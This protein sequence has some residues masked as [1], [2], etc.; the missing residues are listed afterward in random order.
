MAE[1]TNE[2]NAA[3]VRFDP[4]VFDDSVDQVVL[5][6]P[7][8]VH[9]FG[10]RGVVW[11]SLGKLDA[12]RCE[13]V[14]NA[15]EAGLPI[16]IEPVVRDEI[17]RAK[18]FACLRR[19]LLKVLVE[20]LFPTG[21]VDVGGVRYHTVEVK[22]DGVVPVAGDH[23]PA[24]GLPHRSLSCYQRTSLKG[25]ANALNHSWAQRAGATTTSK[26]SWRK[27]RHSHPRTDRIAGVEKLWPS[28]PGLELN[29]QVLPLIRL[30]R[31]FA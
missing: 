18:C 11:M 9:C 16:H 28:F 23:T 19:A 2:F 3:L 27:A 12:A 24:V 31:S 13:K 4:F 5:A 14:A 6:V 10:L 1:L 25:R 29:G 8:P 20:H 17:E 15:V 21:R 30:I 7:E 22:K 26:S